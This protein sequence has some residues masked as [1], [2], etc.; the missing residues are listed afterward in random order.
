[1]RATQ[2]K[3]YDTYIDAFQLSRCGKGGGCNTV[4]KHTLKLTSLFAFKENN[5][6]GF[7]KPSQSYHGNQLGYC[8]KTFS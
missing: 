6:I 2:A 8:E 4:E 1:M 3:C 5:A 7:R